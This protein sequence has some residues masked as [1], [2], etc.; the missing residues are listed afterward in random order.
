MN[1]VVTKIKDT[2]LPMAAAAGMVGSLAAC[3]SYPPVPP[4]P[5]EADM[6]FGPSVA[7]NEYVGMP[8][9]EPIPGSNPKVFWYT[10]PEPAIERPRA[11]P[12]ARQQQTTVYSN[13]PPQPLRRPQAGD[14]AD[15]AGRIWCPDRDRYGNIKYDQRGNVMLEKTHPANC[16]GLRNS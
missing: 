9:P 2:F 1:P 11:A 8:L 4:R 5:P 16:P 15:N 6:Y 14:I 13:I 12:P 10:S 7:R 3:Q